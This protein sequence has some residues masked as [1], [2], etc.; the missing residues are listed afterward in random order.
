MK[1]LFCVKDRVVVITG[2][3]GV[4]GRPM[5]L[6]FAEQG[7]RVVFMGRRPEVG[8]AIEDEASGGEGSAEF[9]A[10]DVLDKEQIEATPTPGSWSDTDASTY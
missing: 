8:Q 10:C 2:A 9:I 7:A 4:L 6:H 5:V 1:N 3:T